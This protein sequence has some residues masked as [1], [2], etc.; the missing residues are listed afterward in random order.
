MNINPEQNYTSYTKALSTQST[1][2]V[3]VQENTLPL[4]YLPIKVNQVIVDSNVGTLPVIDGGKKVTYQDE[5][6]MEIKYGGNQYQ[7]W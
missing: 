7:F 3:L 5:N 6:N 2:K 1:K 4:K